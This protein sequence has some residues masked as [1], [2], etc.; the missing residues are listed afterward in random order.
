MT[1][2]SIR[3]LA[4]LK[5][6][7]L[8]GEVG[9]I[10][11]FFFDDQKWAIR[12][13]VV[14]TGSWFMEKKVLISPIAVSEMNW[15]AIKISLSREQIEKSPDVDTEKPVSRQKETQFHDY[16]RWPYYWTGGAAWGLT[17]YPSVL[18]AQH[19]G[20]APPNAASTAQMDL[21]L[22]DEGE[23]RSGDIHLRSTREVLGYGVEAID[24]SFGHVQDLLI[25]DETWAVRY[26]VIDTINFWPSKNVLLPPSMVDSLSWSERKFRVRLSEQVIK[27]APPYDS[28]RPIERSYEKR[29]F[30]YYGYPGYWEVGPERRVG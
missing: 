9:Q 22:S 17:S 28:A 23:N 12:F 5:P 14:Q 11:Q 7:A 25:D 19:P 13:L 2:R 6:I 20:I 18:V 10:D 4:G 30:G 27:D 21:K 24:K 8:D 3:D 29:L 1:L 16:Y 26:L 15:D